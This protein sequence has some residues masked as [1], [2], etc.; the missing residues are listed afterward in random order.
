MIFDLGNVI[1]YFDET[2]IFKAWS[3]A[4]GKSI[5]EIIKYYSNSSARKSFERGAISPDEFYSKTQ[6]ELNMK[7]SFNKFKKTWNEIFTLNKNVEK[8]IRSLKGRYRL[9]LLSNTNE[10]QYE[11]L[12]KKYQILEV[13]DEYVLSYKAKCRKPNP[14]IFLKAIMKAK[15]LPWNCAYFDDIPEFIFSARLLGIRACQYKNVKKLKNDLNNLK[16]LY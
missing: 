8:I 11:Y 13:F 1:A 3:D 2:G 9:V 7:I 15:T 12:R 10:W 16:I 6:E 14:L 5:P 4:S